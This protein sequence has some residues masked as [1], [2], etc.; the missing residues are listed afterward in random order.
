MTDNLPTETARVA[1][2][3]RDCAVAVM[4]TDTDYARLSGRLFHA[5]D[6][7]DAAAKQ[8][9]EW[10]L[11]DDGLYFAPCGFWSYESADDLKCPCCRCK[12]TVKVTVTGAKP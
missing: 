1:G 8:T 3:L 4:R 11:R 9:C 6:A 12:D 2:V 10:E 5:A 7:L